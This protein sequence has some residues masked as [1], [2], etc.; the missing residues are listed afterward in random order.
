MESY[1]PFRKSPHQKP[2]PFWMSHDIPHLTQANGF[3]LPTSND[4]NPICTSP[5]LLSVV[6]IFN[7]EGGQPNTSFGFFIFRDR[8]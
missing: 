5:V 4:L 6:L 1:K 2:A 7:A 3:S 8:G